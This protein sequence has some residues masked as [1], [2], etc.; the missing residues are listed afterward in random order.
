MDKINKI[1]LSG[2]LNKISNLITLRNKDQV[3]NCSIKYQFGKHDCE[4]SLTAFKEN[5]VAL[6]ELIK[7][8]QVLIEGSLYQETYIRNNGEPG[9]FIKIRVNK[10]LSDELNIYEYDCKNKF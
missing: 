9:K 4:I 6:S 7:G 1:R 3:I 2:Y 8:S 10:I 5:A